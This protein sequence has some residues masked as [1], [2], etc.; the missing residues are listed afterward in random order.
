MNLTLCTS[1][2]EVFNAIFVKLAYVKF[3]NGRV[4]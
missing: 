4:T 3:G 2:V 1:Y